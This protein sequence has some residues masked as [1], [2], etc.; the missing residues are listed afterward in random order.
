MDPESTKS[1]RPKQW[2][3]LPHRV[4]DNEQA[5]DRLDSDM[6]ELKTTMRRSMYGIWALVL[7]LF[8]AAITYWINGGF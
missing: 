5:L 7:Q 6:D 1:W 8:G 2:P 3:D 4:R